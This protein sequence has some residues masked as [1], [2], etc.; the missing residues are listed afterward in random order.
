MSEPIAFTIPAVPIAQPR[1]RAVSFG[2]KARMYGAAVKHPVNAFKASCQMAAMEAYKGAPLDGPVSLLVLFVMPRPQAKIKKR[3]DNP[4]YPHIS[5]PDFDNLGK[6]LCD[7]LTGIL[8][9]DDS[10]LWSVEIRKVV[11]AASEQPRVTVSVFTGLGL[12]EPIAEP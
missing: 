5:R 8:W 1:P 9:R 12:T 11:A 6:S 10:Q 3:G 7:A 2:G 4:R